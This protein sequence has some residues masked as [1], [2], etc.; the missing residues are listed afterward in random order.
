MDASTQQGFTESRFSGLQI[1]LPEAGAVTLGNALRM[2]S[3][4][5]IF[6]TDRPD[7]V[8]KVFDL[9]CGNEEEVSYGPYVSFQLEV[10]NFE[11]IGALGSLHHAIPAY[12]GSGLEFERK[13]SWVAMEFLNGK[14]LQEWCD[15]ATAE[16]CSARW[17]A[18]FRR[19]IYETFSIMERFHENR[20]VLI[21]FKPENVVRLSD[22]NVKFVDMGAFFTPRHYGKTKEYMYSATPDY[23]EL[24]IDSSNIQSGVPLTQAS[25]IFAAGV[26]LFEMVTQESRLTIDDETAESI[27]ADPTAYLFRETQIRDVWQS[28]PHLEGVLPLVETQL[29]EGRLLFAEFWH[30]LRGYMAEE[31]DDWESIEPDTQDSML[32]DTGMNFIR[33]HLP[34]PMHWLAE[35]IAYATVLR[36]LRYESMAEL[37]SLMGNP[38][39]A[40]VRADLE[41]NNQF[42][43]YLRDQGELGDLLDGLNEWDVREHDLSGHWAINAMAGCHFLVDHEDYS[44]VIK[45]EMDDQGHHYYRL[46]GEDANES[47][48]PM[49]ELK[50]SRMG[51]VL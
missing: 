4:T 25:D 1:E 51:W 19:T 17:V 24:L 27:K 39:S 34:E 35:P 36:R 8:I 41:E 37:K 26:A 29:K 40:E 13:F 47:P 23:A 5:A 12:Y 44:Y 28:Y 45:A 21:D 22:G 32:M 30:V 7:I 42:V 11:E 33:D 3:E 10:A 48:I 38:I 20:I 46:S 31:M 50:D 49:M 9:E 14:D 2:A 15:D 43:Q 6:L 18:E 16:G